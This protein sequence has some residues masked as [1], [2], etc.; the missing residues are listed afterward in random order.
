MQTNLFA[1]MDALRDGVCQFIYR[2]KPYADVDCTF[3]PFCA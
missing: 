2:K 3:H 1:T